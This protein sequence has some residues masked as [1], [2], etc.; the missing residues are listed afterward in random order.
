MTPVFDDQL[1][2]GIRRLPAFVPVQQA[3]GDGTHIFTLTIVGNF[4]VLQ[5]A[6]AIGLFRVFSNFSVVRSILR[7]FQDF[8]NLCQYGSRTI[9]IGRGH[10]RRAFHGVFPH[11]QHI[12]HIR[13]AP[14][15]EVEALVCQIF[16]PGV[17][18]VLRPCVLLCPVFAEGQPAGH[19]IIVFFQDTRF[20]VSLIQ[21]PGHQDTGVAP[22]G[23]ALQHHGNLIPLIVD[24]R[25]ILHQATLLLCQPAFAQPF[26]QY[27]I[28][29]HEI[30][31][32]WREH[33]R[34]A[35]PAGP[36]SRR[37]VG[38]NIAEIGAH[39]PQAVLEQTVHIRVSA[40]EETRLRHPG[41]HCDGGEL[42]AR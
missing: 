27:G 29:V 26:A 23:A 13:F 16:L 36:L 42:G 31:G 5:A 34:V 18:F 4:T 14:F 32:G 8:R 11:G 7:F 17:A 9:E 15:A 2:Q 21:R 12:V 30:N 20:P 3:K 19:H 38:G 24:G 10:F 40:G 6:E 22:P 35:R 33:A 39:A 28:T 37:A 1:V 41:I 25:D